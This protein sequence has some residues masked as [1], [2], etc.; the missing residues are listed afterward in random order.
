MCK[1]NLSFLLDLLESN[2]ITFKVSVQ[3]AIGLSLQSLC[4]KGIFLEMENIE[5]VVFYNYS[6]KDRRINILNSRRTIF[7]C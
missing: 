4:E 5:Q 7:V 6:L 1:H 3:K 2:Q